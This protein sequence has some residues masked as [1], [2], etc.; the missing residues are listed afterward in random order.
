[1]SAEALNIAY[2]TIA[3]AIP[4][5]YWY[6]K[7]QKWWPLILAWPLVW[8]GFSLVIFSAMSGQYAGIAMAFLPL[9]IGAW[10]FGK[11]RHKREMRFF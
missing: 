9:M 6:H 8:M 1:M 11:G 10:F 5:I 4:V 2:I 7:P 3:I